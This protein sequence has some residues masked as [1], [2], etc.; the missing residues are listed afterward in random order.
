MLDRIKKIINEVLL[1]N[2]KQETLEQFRENTDF[3][4]EFSK[5]A[6]ENAPEYIYDEGSNII[7][8]FK[9]E[10]AKEQGVE[11]F[12]IDDDDE[13]FKTWLY[14]EIGYA[15]G[16]VSRELDGQVGDLNPIPIARAIQID[17]DYIEQLSSFGKHLGLYWTWN[18]NSAQ[19]YWGDDSDRNKY[20]VVYI[21]EAE[22]PQ[23]YVNWRYTVLQ[24]WVS[25]DE[26]EI[27]LQKGV[28]LRIKNLY[29]LP[30]GSSNVYLRTKLDIEGIKDKIFYA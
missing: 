28:P 8:D 15:L 12:E 30:R 27:R 22:V 13:D 10:Y 17:G 7:D 29:V 1:I 24:N 5:W 18:L 11:W 16:E 21:I 14:E 20:G 9:E 3:Y 2:E 26:K 19:A 25:P 6:Y 4:G 23:T